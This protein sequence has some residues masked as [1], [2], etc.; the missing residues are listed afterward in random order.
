[1]K[2]YGYGLLGSLLAMFAVTLAGKLGF[3]L[4]AL[5]YGFGLLHL[6]AGISSTWSYLLGITIIL[7]LLTNDH[8]GLWSLFCLV[9]W[10][11]NFVFHQ[12]LRFTSNTVRFLSAL[13]LLFTAY[14]LFFSSSNAIYTWLPLL[15]ACMI[16]ALVTILQRTNT[17]QPLY[18]LN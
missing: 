7:E 13:A 16:L 8:F 1:M 12:R 9:V 17:I 18:G 3:F 6:F 2:P 10:I 11:L 14:H 15:I 5:L 4:I